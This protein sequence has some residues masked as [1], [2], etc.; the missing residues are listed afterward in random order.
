MRRK[1]DIRGYAKERGVKMVEVAGYL[2]ISKQGLSNRI[3]R[4][5]NI[6]EEEAIKKAAEE[7]SKRKIE[8]GGI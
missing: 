5:L 6:V 2:G 7:I 1:E 3:R 4:G 8:R